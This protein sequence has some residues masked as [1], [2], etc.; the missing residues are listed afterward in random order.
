MSKK[1]L[2]TCPPMIKQISNYKDKF[3]EYNFDVYCPEFQQTMTED[4][5]IN[6]V[7][8]YDGWIIGD[9]PATRKVFEAG[10]KGKLK[11]CVKWG[12]GVDNVDFV[13]CKDLNIP[14]SN[15]PG[16][17]GE[18]VSDI[19]IGYLLCLT[20]KIHTINEENRKGN[21]V[22]PCGTSLTGKKVC[23]IGFGDIGRC[24]ARKLLAFN[25]NIYVSDPGFEQVD[26]KIKC[27]YNKELKI[28]ESLNNVKI[29]SFED[30][31]TDAD[32]IILTCSLNKK[33]YHM[34]NAGNI[35]LAKKGVKI[36]NVARGPLVNENDVIS[37]QNSGFI[38][39]IAFDVLEEEPLNKNNRLLLNDGNMFGSHN[40]SNTLEAVN[41]TTQIAISKLYE[42]LT[43]I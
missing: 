35:I 14:I 25:L 43:S 18:E 6:I 8:Q 5:L 16:M 36:I 39:S 42:F 9:D 15:T 2:V 38:D 24:T 3:E 41:N 10:I 23:L 1:I 28:N 20:R 19:A 32:F 21:W 7:P 30:A 13:A 31:L 26:G 29:T 17:F 22:K 11:A 40:G 12:V 34:L 37:L 33:T 27:K 4:E